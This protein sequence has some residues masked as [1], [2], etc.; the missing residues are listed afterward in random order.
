MAR[1]SSIE[2]LPPDIKKW[3]VRSIIDRSY[4][5]YD[6]LL[7]ELQGRGYDLS[8]SALA[9]FG[10]KLMIQSEIARLIAPDS[11]DGERARIEQ[12]RLKCLEFA[13]G[14]TPEKRI[15]AAEQYLAWV[16]KP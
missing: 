15:A 7:M 9:R 8:R 16:L 12:I 10:K 11:P 3:L 5:T 14:E 2:G 6:S 1:N 4:G 13:K